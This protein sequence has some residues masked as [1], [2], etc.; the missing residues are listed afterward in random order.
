MIVLIVVMVM[1]MMAKGQTECEDQETCA[2]C[3]QTPGCVWCSHPNKVLT[4]YRSTQ[5][6]YL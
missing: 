5:N 4:K 3:I 1:V 2:H 6:I